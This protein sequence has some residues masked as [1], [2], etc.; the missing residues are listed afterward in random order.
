[1]EGHR[2]PGIVHCII[3]CIVDFAVFDDFTTASKINSSNS[4]YSIESYDILV[5]PQNL[6]C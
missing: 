2:R 5:V 4:Y 1:M 6:I 3:Y